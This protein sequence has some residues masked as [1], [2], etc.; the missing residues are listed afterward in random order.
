MLLIVFDKELKQ[1]VQY[2]HSS[3]I[4][5]ITSG[6]MKFIVE[7]TNGYWYDIPIDFERYEVRYENKEEI[8]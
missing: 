3:E 8:E 5:G 4:I 7:D 6:G 2:V 1:C